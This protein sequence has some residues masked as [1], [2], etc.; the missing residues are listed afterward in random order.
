MADFG[1]IDK[2]IIDSTL[3]P[4][5]PGS[6]VVVYAD[7]QFLRV[8][9]TTSDLPVIANPMTNQG[10]V[11]VAGASGVPQRLAKG[12]ANQVFAMD[13]SGTN[14]TWT[15][16]NYQASNANLTSLSGLANTKGSLLAMNGTALT[17]LGVGTD[18]QVIVANSATSTGLGWSSTAAAGVSSLTFAQ[19]SGIQLNNSTGALTGKQKPILWIYSSVDGGTYV[20][21]NGSYGTYWNWQEAISIDPS[22]SLINANPNTKPSTF[23]APFSGLYSFIL[24]CTKVAAGPIMVVLNTTTGVGT[25]FEDLSQGASVIVQFNA[26]DSFVICADKGTVSSY[27]SPGTL[28][29]QYLGDS[30]PLISPN[31]GTQFTAGPFSGSGNLTIGTFTIPSDYLPGSNA[32]LTW[33]YNCTGL[34]APGTGTYVYNFGIFRSGF[35]TP[36]SQQ[37]Y[38]FATG[39]TDP[40][41]YNLTTQNITTY[42]SGVFVP[43]E[44]ITCGFQSPGSEGG[45]TSV[46]LFVYPFQYVSNT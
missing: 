28:S 29:I 44:T 45:V 23:T 10:D 35:T 37:T 8:V 1:N 36:L 15:T 39:S 46:N 42:F 9:N 17:E 32:V 27:I 18:G 31:S 26:G 3:S 24:S 19:N 25:Y 2:L 12:T 34:L 43:G 30:N 7:T 21:G 13:G 5:L 20:G 6:G 33:N 22:A 14:E 40:T 4:D 16:L 41:S 11:I 38:T